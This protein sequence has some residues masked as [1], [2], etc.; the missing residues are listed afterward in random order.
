MRIFITDVTLRDGDHAMN[1]QFTR[2]QVARI[3]RGLD[4]AGVDIIE[5]SHGDGLGWLIPTVRHESGTRRGTI[6]GRG[7]GPDAC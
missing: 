5:C 6:A 4:T 2:D 3:A 1:H 7:R